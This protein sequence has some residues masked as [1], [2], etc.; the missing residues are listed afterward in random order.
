M[1]GEG[2]GYAGT[3]V[4]KVAVPALAVLYLNAST[5]QVALLAFAATVPAL[6]VSLPAGVLVDRHPARAVLIT[7]DLAAAAVALLIP[8]AAVLDM[9]TMPLLYSTA[10]ALGSLSVLHT[11]ASMAAIPLLAGSRQFHR[12]NSHFTA[13]ITTAGVTGSALGTVLVATAG[14]ARA[15]V[16]DV[17]SFV[18]SAWCAVRAQGLP[19]PGQSQAARRP[20]L[21]EIREGLRYSAGN[22]VLRPLFL[23]LI[24]T[25]VGSGLTTTLLAYH[26]LTTVRVGTTGLGSIMAAGSLGGLTGALIA[27]R[28]VGRYGSGT[29][30]AVGFVVHALMQMPPIVAT[31]GPVWLTVL[32]LAGF[33]HFA[34]ATCVGTTQR[35]VQQW[36]SP[37]RLRARVQ[38]TALW[39]IN[40]FRPLAALAA[41]AFALFTS[42]RAVMFIGILV[43]LLF[44]ATLWCSPVRRLTAKDGGIA[45]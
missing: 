41:G 19:A 11:A 28:L 38:Q 16:A 7:T 15:L 34:A 44:A 42:V 24:G 43:L 4:H 22:R 14:P 36:Y 2:I 40:G 45:Q 6:L 29:V 8:A 32:T 23:T 12:A 17:L 25:G 39:L 27:P 18:I 9:L 13:V 5:G 30:L 33:G 37:P 1:V 10:L 35:T 26:L 21:D 3:A 20:M 31:P